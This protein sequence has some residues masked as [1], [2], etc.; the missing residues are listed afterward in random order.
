MSAFSITYGQQASLEDILADV[1]GDDVNVWEEATGNEWAK[2]VELN[3]LQE[4]IN[5]ASN[6]NHGAADDILEL[7]DDGAWTYANGAAPSAQIISTTSDSA[8]IHTTLAMHNGLDVLNYTVFYFTAPL[9]T[10]AYSDIVSKKII[11]KKAWEK[12]EL[13]L[14]WLEK[15]TTYYSV[16]APVNP[17]DESKEPL[18]NLT[19]EISFKTKNEIEATPEPV[20]VPEENIEKLERVTYKTNENNVELSWEAPTNSNNKVDI[21]LRHNDD[22]SY[23]AIGNIGVSTETFSFTVDKAWAYFIKLKMMDQNGKQ[24]GADSNLNLSIKEF[25]KDTS[26]EITNPP[27]VGPTMDLMIALA[28]FAALMY[29]VYRVRRSNSD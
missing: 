6:A 5:K 4:N 20:A 13:L 16:V 2:T 7:M 11:W 24:I 19:S 17:E 25:Q 22:L 9:S 8:T 18:D 15:N 23:T 10:S 12:V 27:K 3:A 1:L 29:I 28:I 14:N 26:P 21:S